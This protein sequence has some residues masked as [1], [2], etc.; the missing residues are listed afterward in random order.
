LLNAKA[1]VAACCCETLNAKAAVA[2]CCTGMTADWQHMHGTL[3]IGWQGGCIRSGAG[4]LS[5]ATTWHHAFKEQASL[6]L[7]L[8]IAQGG[9]SDAPTHSHA[10]KLGYVF[11]LPEPSDRTVNKGCMPRDTVAFSK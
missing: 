10:F 6:L 7:L 4:A 11:T 1:A 8:R 2:A 9:L 5:A 3:Q